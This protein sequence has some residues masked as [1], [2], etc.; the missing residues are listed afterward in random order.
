MKT[1]QERN[2]ILN[3]VRNKCYLA[4]FDGNPEEGG[5]EIL[6][7]RK[8]VDFTGAS[9]GYMSST[10][11]LD[12]TGGEADTVLKGQTEQNTYSGKNL[13]AGPEPVE[14][15]G[16]K[17]TRNSD[18]SYN[19]TGAKV[20]SGDMEVVLFETI[21]NTHIVNGEE[22]TFS[23]NQTLPSGVAIRCEAY[24]GSS[25]VRAVI[26]T[27]SDSGSET[28]GTANLNG[29]T[30]I[31]F[32]IIIRDNTSKNIENLCIQL[33][34]G[35]TATDYEPYVGGVP[36]PNPDYPQDVQNIT[37]GNV[38]LC[39]IGDHQD[40]LYTE[41]GK[42]YVHKATGKTQIT[43]FSRSDPTQSI[44]NR[45]VFALPAGA[46]HPLNTDV[47]AG[48]SNMAT[49]THAGGTWD[50]KNTWAF[51][52]GDGLAHLT[53]TANMTLVDANTWLASHPFYIYYPLTT[54][55]DTEITDQA[56]ISALEEMFGNATGVAKYWGVYDSE[57]GGTLLYYF[58]LPYEVRIVKDST[59]TIKA[60]NCVLKEG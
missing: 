16:I 24:N 27:L 10:N 15:S 21:E 43:E 11:Q 53:A 39:K 8:K 55:T 29:A 45:F 59:I 56:T 52:G 44:G 33:E 2:R 31:R 22:Y 49:L 40:Y 57:V 20:T 32:G 50:S 9:M 58:I 6:T 48:Y 54:P 35:S 1:I 12:F 25:W 17:I 37:I 5:K 28:H 51:T 19:I 4:F 3:E 38:E 36:S 30:R 41:N 42:W 14:H 23:C 46:L 60:G 26:P 7:G 13:Y 18:S 34:K 47:G